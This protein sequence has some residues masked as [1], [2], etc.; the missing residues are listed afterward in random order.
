MSWGP[1]VRYSSICTLLAFAVQE[2]MVVHQMDAVTAFLN[3]EEHLVCRLKRSPYG[4]KQSPRYWNTLF[5]AFMESAKFEQILVVVRV[6]IL[7][8]L[9]C[10]L[11]T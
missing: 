10:T 8:S 5:T 11:M 4:I 3:D 1:V 2:G 6:L 9:L 7:Q